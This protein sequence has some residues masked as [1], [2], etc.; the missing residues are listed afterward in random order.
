MNKSFTG[1]EEKVLHW[2]K[3][4]KELKETATEE[5]GIPVLNRRGAA[6]IMKRG[7]SGVKIGRQCYIRIGSICRNNIGRS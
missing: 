7:L 2:N 1:L 4:R 5:G 3:Q 6:L